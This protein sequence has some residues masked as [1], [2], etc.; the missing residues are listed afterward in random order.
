MGKPVHAFLLMGKYGAIFSAGL[1]QYAMELNAI[2]GVTAS[3]HDYGFWW[4]ATA[5]ENAYSRMV[6]AKAKTHAVVLIGHS[7]GATGASMIAR[8]LARLGHSV[9]LV[10]SLDCSRWSPPIPLGANVRRAVSLYDGAN[11]IGGVPLARSPFFQGSWVA[12][13]TSGIL[14]SRFDDD[15]G[16]RARAI[17]EV[18]LTLE[19]MHAPA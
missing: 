19:D 15:P 10:F 18:E 7:F 2:E 16:F 13:D 11:L 3:V 4:P 6:A 5:P 8:D 12:Q 17:R 1:Q 14:H 9:A